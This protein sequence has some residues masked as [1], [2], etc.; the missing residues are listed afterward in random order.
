VSLDAPARRYLDWLPPQYATITV[1][2]LLTHTAGVAPDMRLE[3]IDEISEEEFKRR[4][5]GRPPSF[6]PGTSFQYA[7]AGYTLLSQIV[8]RVS[9]QDFGT[10]LKQRIFDP[11][12]M[13]K[14]SYRRPAVDDDTHAVG[15]DLV[16]GR[17]SEMP[18]IF[19]GRGN[20]GIESTAEDLARFA[21][22]LQT[23]RLLSAKS[24]EA[25]FSPGKLA[26]DTALNFPFRSARSAYGFGWFITTDRGD[27]LITHGGAIAG[28]SSV[29]HR[30][31]G[32]NWTIIVLANAKQ[33]TDRQG[34]A[35]AVA[36]LLLEALRR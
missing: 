28:F 9:R 10:F 3:N 32:R 11:L 16:D 19:A 12:G 26:A 18:H 4:F 7:N 30:L 24:Y 36:G 13:R 14:T 31:P 27:S 34:Q 23:R 29:L 33:G 25:M 8:E 1:R 6:S 15:Y 2:Q 22:A 20:S 35:E 21:R 5:I 17:L